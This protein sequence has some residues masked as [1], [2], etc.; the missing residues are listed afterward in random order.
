MHKLNMELLKDSMIL[1]KEKLN[2]VKDELIEIQK[3]LKMLL[4]ETAFQIETLDLDSQTIINLICNYEII[5]YRL[6]SV[7]NLLQEMEVMNQVEL[8]CQSLH[9]IEYS[10]FMQKQS[11]EWLREHFRTKVKG[12]NDATNTGTVQC[13]VTIVP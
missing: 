6:Q 2:K 9:T 5:Q 7:D 8:A 3:K 11:A 4:R 1:N 12:E 13:D 10:K